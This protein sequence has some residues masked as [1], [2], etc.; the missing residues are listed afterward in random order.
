L[1]VSVLAVFQTLGFFLTI[2]DVPLRW[3]ASRALGGL[4]LVLLRI[5]RSPEAVADAGEAIEAALNAGSTQ[6]VQRIFAWAEV[7]RWRVVALAP[8]LPFILIS[9]FMKLVLFLWTCLLLGPPL[10]VLWRNRRYSADAVAVQLTRDPDA[11]ALALRQITE[12][13]VPPG[14]S[15]REY[16]F[17]HVP[18]ATLAEQNRGG[19]GIRMSLHPPISRRL[20]RLV[21]MG[22]NDVGAAQSLWGSLANLARHPARAALATGLFLL[23]V[24][25]V[26]ALGFMVAYVTALILTIV[27]CVGLGL[28]SS[29]L[30]G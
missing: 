14:G 21:A 26:A 19:S 29:V 20:A 16:F 9:L 30:G 7:S 4:V 3:S 22:A 28:A 18:A 6:P 17:I 25:V 23:L 12:A 13:S 15:G 5:R 8:L 2:L 27:L 24:P 10:A 11:L 1:S